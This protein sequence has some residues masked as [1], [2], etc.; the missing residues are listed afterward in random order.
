[1]SFENQFQK[2]FGVY[3]GT[4]HEDNEDYVLPCNCDKFSVTH[5]FDTVEK[6]LLFMRAGLEYAYEDGKGELC[7]FVVNDSEQVCKVWLRVAEKQGLTVVSSPSR[8]AKGA[9]NVHMIFVKRGQV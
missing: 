8:V 5:V 2:E 7:L 1:M 4:Y 9:Y 6:V 3:H